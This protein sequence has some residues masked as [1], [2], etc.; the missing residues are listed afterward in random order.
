MILK[1][2]TGIEADA[3]RSKVELSIHKTAQW[4]KVKGKSWT[5]EPWTK[6]TIKTKYAFLFLSPLLPWLLFNKRTFFS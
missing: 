2:Q 5:E 4:K 1:Q 3:K 6:I